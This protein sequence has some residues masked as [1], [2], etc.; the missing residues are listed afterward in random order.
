ISVDIWLGLFMA[1]KD[2]FLTEL[3]GKVQLETDYSWGFAQ[4]LSVVIAL[5]FPLQIY[6]AWSGIYH[7]HCGVENILIVI[8]DQTEYQNA[9]TLAREPDPRVRKEKRTRSHLQRLYEKYNLVPD[10]DDGYESDLNW[11]SDVPL[12]KVILAINRPK[13]RKNSEIAPP[14]TP[15]DEFND[16]GDFKVHV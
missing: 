3:T 13:E 12:Y 11:E 15:L 4:V 7:R 8:T 1:N 5:G 14:M 6:Q 10:Q 2:L 9:L 16:R